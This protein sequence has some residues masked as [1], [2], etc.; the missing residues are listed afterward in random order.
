MMVALN[1]DDRVRA[2]LQWMQGAGFTR[3]R[4]ETSGFRVRQYLG[5]GDDRV[6]QQWAVYLI[7]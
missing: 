5:F 3:I 1:Q 2:T 7:K 6:E 4:I